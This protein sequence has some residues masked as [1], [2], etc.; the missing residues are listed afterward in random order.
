[1]PATARA[2][3]ACVAPIEGVR[4]AIE[5]GA[6]R[7]A[8]QRL[9]PAGAARNAVDC[10]LWDLEAKRSGRRACRRGGLRPPDAARHR[11]HAVG[12][13]ARG[14]A[15]GRD[16]RRRPAAPEGEARRRRRRWRASPR[17]ARARPRAA[18]IVDANEAWREET[19]VAQ[20]DA[21][22]RRRRRAGRAA[23]AGGDGRNARPASP[24][25]CPICAD[26]SA[27]E[28]RQPRRRCAAATT[29]STSSSTRP[30]A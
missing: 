6:D 1:M 4:A 25:R 26:E 20:L 2:S 5:A 15:R 21:C 14:D 7:A 24:G 23:A 8:L 19:L 13:D 10:A 17:S 16:E 18:L 11:L 22:A 27:H 28:T 29:R 3:K 30:A 9:L 12:R